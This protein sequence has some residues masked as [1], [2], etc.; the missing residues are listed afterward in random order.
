MSNLISIRNA[1][2]AYW[3]H[4]PELPKAIKKR[5][6]DDLNIVFDNLTLNLPAGIVSI[7]GENGIGKSTLLLLMGARLFPAQGQ[8]LIA[9]R[10]SRDFSEALSD[11][12]VEE[13]RNRLVSF[14]FQNMEFES[15]EK[16]GTLLDIVQSQN[17]HIR[18][19]KS[20]LQELP[21]ALDIQSL[22]HRRTQELSKGELQRAVIALAISYGSRILIMDE[23]VFALEEHHKKQV[24]LYLREV[25]SKTGTSLYYTAHDIDICREYADTMLLLY[26]D[27][28]YKLGAP[29]EVCTRENLEEAYRVPIATLYQKEHLYRDMLLK[30]SGA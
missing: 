21:Q 24:F 23:P 9:D 11:P 6:L 7:L 3:K 1:S 30:K 13:E 18:R 22:L 26:Q 25:C 17:P 2:F 16:L 28:N 4:E 10:D 20:T 29:H 19:G 27:Q 5:G 8:I 12:A 14:V 15:E